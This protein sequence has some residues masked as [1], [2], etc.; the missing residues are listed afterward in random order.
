MV[1]GNQKPRS[2]FLPRR[3]WVSHEAAANKRAGYNTSVSAVQPAYF[4]TREG[5]CCWGGGGSV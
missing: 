1:S 5:V 4:Q 3:P 2:A